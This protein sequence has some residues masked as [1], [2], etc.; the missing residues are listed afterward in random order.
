[1]VRDMEEE[2]KY[3]KM[4]VYMMDTGETIKQTERVD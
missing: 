2:N 4:G 1:M 3:G